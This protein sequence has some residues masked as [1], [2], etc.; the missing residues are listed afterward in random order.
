MTLES[1][2]IEWNPTLLQTAYQIIKSRSFGFSLKLCA[3]IIENKT[4]I[5]IGSMSIHKSR[6]DII[7]S[8]N[9]SPNRLSQ[10]IPR[11]IGTNDTL[12]VV[13][14]LVHN[15]PLIDM[16]LEMG[17]NRGNMLFKNME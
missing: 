9:S 10:L 17:N 7:L 16:P 12:V 11:R 14:T 4:G 13:E 8:Y 2:S 1:H 15:V 3:I 5:G 6:V